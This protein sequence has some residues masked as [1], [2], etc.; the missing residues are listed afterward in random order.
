MLLFLRCAAVYWS[1][2]SRGLPV[3]WTMPKLVYEANKTRPHNGATCCRIGVR[4]LVDEDVHKMTTQFQKHVHAPNFRNNYIARTYFRAVYRVFA[5]LR[6]EHFAIFSRHCVLFVRTLFAVRWL[7]SSKARRGNQRAFLLPP[8]YYRRCSLGSSLQRAR[9]TTLGMPDLLVLLL[10]QE[11]L[12]SRKLLVS[13]YG[14]TDP[15]LQKVRRYCLPA[16]VVCG[17]LQVSVSEVQSFKGGGCLLC[18]FVLY[19]EV[20]PLHGHNADA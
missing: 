19:P 16:V 11:T 12:S 13:Q 17:E 10:G 1:M 15:H 3:A 5:P 14:A 18:H 6:A 7:I 4:G 20:R 9:R 2:Y 8:L